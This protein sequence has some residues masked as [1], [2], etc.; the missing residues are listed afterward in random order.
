MSFKLSNNILKEIHKTT[1]NKVE[2]FSQTA[3]LNPSIPTTKLIATTDYV[4]Y[5]PNGKIGQQKIVTTVGGN[6]NVTIN[7]NSGYTDSGTNTV[8]LYD[9]GDMVVFWASINGWHY[10]SFIYD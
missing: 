1:S 2:T 7:F 5:L 4:V 3:T 6:S 9:E 8:T 10:S